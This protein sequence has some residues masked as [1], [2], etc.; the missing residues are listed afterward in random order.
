MASTQTI[1]CSRF[2]THVRI[3]SGYVLKNSTRAGN[4]RE[5]EKKCVTK[6]YSRQFIFGANAEFRS[7]RKSSICS[8]SL[9]AQNLLCATQKKRNKK[10]NKKKL[11]EKNV[12]RSTVSGDENSYIEKQRDFPKLISKHT[13]NFGLYLQFGRLLDASKSSIWIAF[14]LIRVQ[15]DKSVPFIFLWFGNPVQFGHF[16]VMQIG[17]SMMY[18][19]ID[20]VP[21][22]HVVHVLMWVYPCVPE[23]C[24]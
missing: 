14:P 7:T 20:C 11:K 4:A 18:H 8:P 9:F 13:T 3:W 2:G 16:T 23:I 19:P 15:N 24:E 22:V 17:F 10:Q 5:R 12:T 6:T 1:L 21:N